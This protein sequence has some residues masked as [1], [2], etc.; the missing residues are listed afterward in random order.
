[1]FRDYTNFKTVF[2]KNM[3]NLINI[4]K[5]RVRDCESKKLLETFSSMQNMSTG[6][7]LYTYIYLIEI[8]R[9]YNCLYVPKQ[10]LYIL[11][12]FMLYILNILYLKL[13]LCR[14][15][16]I[17]LNKIN[18]VSRFKNVDNNVFIALYFHSHL[19]KIN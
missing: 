18:F 16:K 9:C 1:M 10:Y 19:K 13:I 3:D 17:K 4:L 6:N 2:E 5:E 14:I 15:I 12:R 8:F 11:G 7:Y